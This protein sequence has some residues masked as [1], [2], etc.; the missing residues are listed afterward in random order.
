MQHGHGKEGSDSDLL[1]NH[2]FV[3]QWVWPVWPNFIPSSTDPF[4]HSYLTPPNTPQK[5]R[6]LHQG[7]TH[8]FLEPSPMGWDLRDPGSG[9]TDAF[10]RGRWCLHNRW[11]RCYAFLKGMG[12]NDE[13]FTFSMGWIPKTHEHRIHCRPRGPI[14]CSWAHALDSISWIEIHEILGE[15]PIC[16]HWFMMIYGWNQ[17][18]SWF[19]WLPRK[20]LTSTV[21]RPPPQPTAPT[22]P[23]MTTPPTAGLAVERAGWAHRMVVEPRIFIPW[24]P[25]NTGI[26]LI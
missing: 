21:P 2:L 7:R 20:A 10:Q 3:I 18:F 17:D 19:A 1:R 26:Y 4:P 25:S 13:A 14:P 6:F 23:P 22:T 15:L 11:I 24:L 8:I 12:K 5:P 16:L 9:E